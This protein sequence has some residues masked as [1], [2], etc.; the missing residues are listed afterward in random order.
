MAASGARED[1][2]VYD[3]EVQN[4]GRVP[5]NS[6]IPDSSPPASD[7]DFVRALKNCRLGSRPYY[8]KGDILRVINKARRS[9]L[10]G[11]SKRIQSGTVDAKSELSRWAIRGSSTQTPRGSGHSEKP[12]L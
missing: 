3:E 9:A 12:G 10:S 4:P 1:F 8:R 11:E 6:P 2:T 5:P 7:A